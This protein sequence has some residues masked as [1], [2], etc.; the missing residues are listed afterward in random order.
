MEELSQQCTPSAQDERG[1]GYVNPGTVHRKVAK[2]PRTIY[3]LPLGS[4][5]G[6]GIR[7]PTSSVT[8]DNLA[9]SHAAGASQSTVALGRFA[10]HGSGALRFDQGG[11]ESPYTGLTSP[12]W[13]LNFE[14]GLC[15]V[16][17]ERQGPSALGS[18]G[19]Q[20]AAQTGKPGALEI[21]RQDVDALGR[22]T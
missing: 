7:A 13:T 20:T 1:Y 2:K 19:G 12:F 14:S 4:Q 18:R 3:A 6:A 15:G 10:P 11:R 22:E 5:P 21:L 9:N 17:V 8:R 16:P